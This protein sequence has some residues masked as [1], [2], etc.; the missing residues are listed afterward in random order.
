MVKHWDR[1]RRINPP[2]RNMPGRSHNLLSAA[3][4]A[5]ALEG[6]AIHG[7]K[8]DRAQ[9]VADLEREM[10]NNTSWV[11]IHAA[12]GLL[13]NGEPDNI[14]A[15]FRP[16]EDSAVA[17]YR[18]GV[19]RVLARA[20]SG[21]A[22]EQ[23]IE[24][25]RAVVRDPAAP[26]RLSAAES[27]GKLQVVDRADREIVVH[28][29]ATANDASAPFLY[30]LLILSSL[31]S[32]REAN[33]ASLAKLLSSSDTV[34]RLR[35]AFVL[36][37]LKTLSPASISALQSQL[38]AEPSNSI[39]H[40]YLITALLLHEPDKRE[41]AGLKTELLRYLHGRPNE[42]LEAGIVLGLLG[43]N[44]D[45]AVLQPLMNSPEPDSRIGAANGMLRL[46]K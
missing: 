20:T 40:F 10:H 44:E 21:K 41:S 28:W 4:L 42:Q 45:L 26:D 7:V 33:E 24:R 6:C 11:R 5:V 15:T 32:E 2:W 35:T 31:P 43:R 22:R 13:D 19:W 1:Y 34:A 23:Y 14:P 25:L 38:K 39:A 8:I 46:L 18:I 12:E 16:E 29:L 27:L 9:L 30:W 37:R 3:A 36:G 17:P